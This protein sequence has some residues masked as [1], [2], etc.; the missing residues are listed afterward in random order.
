M[1]FDELCNLEPNLLVLANDAREYRDDSQQPSFC[2]NWIWY[3][4]GLRQRLIRLVGW[5]SRHADPI[6]RSQ[7]AYDVAYRAIYEML[8]DCRGC[9]C[10]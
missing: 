7:A 1:T 2:A 3:R 6:V 5:H 8:P 4:K 10:C 9:E